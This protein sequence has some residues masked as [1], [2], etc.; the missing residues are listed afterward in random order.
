VLLSWLRLCFDRDDEAITEQRTTTKTGIK[1]IR[2]YDSLPCDQVH[3]DSTLS[4]V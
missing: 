1:T 4:I 3:I 2:P